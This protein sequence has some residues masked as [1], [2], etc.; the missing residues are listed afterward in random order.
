MISYK[1]HRVIEVPLYLALIFVT[2]LFNNATVLSYLYI[3]SLGLTFFFIYKIKKVS[4]LSLYFFA[5]AIF[6]LYV[7]IPSINYLLLGKALFLAPTD[8]I[9]SDTEFYHLGQ[10]LKNSTI[11]ILIYSSISM[12]QI[13]KVSKGIL[14]SYQSSLILFTFGVVLLLFQVFH[15]GAIAHI[16]DGG[17]FRQQMGKFPPIYTY[18]IY[19]GLYLMF[20]SSKS[21]LNFYFSL[22]MLLIYILFIIYAGT[23]GAALAALFISASGYFRH[24]T[25]SINRKVI[26]RI[27]LLFAIFMFFTVRSRMPDNRPNMS[28]LEFIKIAPQFVNPGT[29]E[30]GTSYYNFAIMNEYS[31]HQDFPFQIYYEQFVGPTAISPTGDTVSVFYKYRDMYHA[32]RKEKSGSSG[33]TGY[34]LQYEFYDNLGSFYWLMYLLMGALFYYISQKNKYS[35]NGISEL[36]TVMLIP[37]IV[38]IAR[39]NF[40]VAILFTKL[41]YAIILFMAFSL[42]FKK[43]IKMKWRLNG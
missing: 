2:I 35:E 17:Y 33:G 41:I 27:V 11:G 28:M 26:V 37:Y 13:G 38:T 40:I 8:K 39:S 25:F 32:E 23:R 42:L 12:K 19:I 1:N 5:Y 14:L 4:L 24:R 30:Y 15:T 6:N 18:F 16:G 22:F 10:Y 43:H 21:W 3:L 36:Y 34:S 9:F 31:F 20:K 7:I 29:V